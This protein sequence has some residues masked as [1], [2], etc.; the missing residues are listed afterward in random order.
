MTIKYNKLINYIERKGM[1]LNTLVKKKVITDDAAKKIR[2]GKSVN[3]YHIESACLF[4][5]VPI[6]ALVEITRGESPESD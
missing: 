4:L 6:E 2:A 5:D 1:S 3:L